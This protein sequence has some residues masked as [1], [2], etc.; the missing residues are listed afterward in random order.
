M[1]VGVALVG[2]AM[3]DSRNDDG[4]QEVDSLQFFYLKNFHFPFLIPLYH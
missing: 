2:G 4:E 3:C 1:V